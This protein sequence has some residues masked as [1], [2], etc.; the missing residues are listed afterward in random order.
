MITDF[1]SLCA[2]RYASVAM[3]RRKITTYAM[4]SRCPP[5][6]PP[7][8]TPPLTPPPLA[9]DGEE[10]VPEV[11]YYYL[12]DEEEN[13]RLEAEAQAEIDNMDWAIS[14][15]EDEEQVA[16]HTSWHSLRMENKEAAL[17]DELD[18]LRLEWGLKVSRDRHMTEEGARGFMEL[19]RQRLLELLAEDVSGR[20]HKIMEDDFLPAPRR[21]TRC[22]GLAVPKKGANN[23]EAG[24]SRR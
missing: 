10:E 13:D 8:P 11:D 18:D 3:V 1:I 17:D 4:M 21:R 12:E 5:P 15:P 14:D 20:L 16:I 24:P 9:S 6:P 2:F 7:H 19:E 22:S 23:N